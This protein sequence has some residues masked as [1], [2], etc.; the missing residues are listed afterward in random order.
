MLT[1]LIGASFAAYGDVGI[2]DPEKLAHIDFLNQPE[3]L[4]KLVMESG[5]SESTDMLKMK[6]VTRN[7]MQ[8]MISRNFPP[9]TPHHTQAF[10]ALMMSRFLQVTRYNL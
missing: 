6:E 8:Y 2:F 9:L 5:G 7:W 4:V 1:S 10:A 3:E